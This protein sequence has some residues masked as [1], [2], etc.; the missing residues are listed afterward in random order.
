MTDQAHARAPR[1]RWLSHVGGALAV[2]T[3]AGA[4]WGV[5]GCG[6]HNANNSST[7]GNGEDG[8]GPG[9]SGSSGGSSGSGGTNCTG[10]DVVAPKRL[11]RLTFNQIVNTIGAVLPNPNTNGVS[12]IQTQLTTNYQI[13]DAQH[14][15][16]PPLSSPREGAVITQGVW[17]QDDLMARDVGQFVFNNFPSVTNCTNVTDMCAQTWL[18]TFAQGVFRRPLSSD[19]TSALMA[20]YTNDKNL[21]GSVQEATQYTVYAALSAPQFLYRTEF[22]TDQSK[23]GPLTPYELASEISYFLTDGPPD[24]QLLSAAASNSLSTPAQLQAQVS[25]LLVLPATKA[26]LEAAM[27]S[28]FGIPTIETVVI[29]TTKFPAWNMGLA[30]SMRHETELFLHNTLWSGVVGD[31]LLS[32]KSSINNTLASFYGISPFPQGGSTPDKDGFALTTVPSNRSG[33]VTQS[34]F[35]VARANPNAPS[36]VKRGLLFNGSFL[37][38]TNPPFPSDP[39]IVAQVQALSANTNLT[40]RQK[41]DYRAKTSPCNGCHP[42]FDPYGEALGNYDTL[43]AYIT[44]DTD[45][46]MINATVTLPPLAGGVEVHNAVE[47]AQALAKAG[48]FLNCMTNNVIAYALAE[49]VVA[50]SVSS[51]STTDIASAATAAGGS[52]SALVTQIASSQTLAARMPGGM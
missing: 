45:G 49:P 20:V 15:T 22:G 16:F 35:L 42:G 40:E 11:I 19:E 36:I 26:N 39:A 37:C 3:A 28:Y 30:N 6:A 43:G 5:P 10:N 46:S 48:A 52:F 14:R 47:M 29:D 50:A 41:A 12:N 32:S 17:T 38:G 27:F 13:V 23:M 9:G 34:G 7:N 21:G 44:T 24:T 8:G 2:L 51:C 33:I 18:G 25:R 4:A 31:L 1:K